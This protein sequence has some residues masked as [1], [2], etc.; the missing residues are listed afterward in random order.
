MTGQYTTLDKE[1]RPALETRDPAAYIATINAWHT[2]RL[3]EPL[4]VACSYEHVEMAEWLLQH[5]LSPNQRNRLKGGETPLH[6]AVE[7]ENAALV[8]V[9]ARYGAGLLPNHQGENPLQVYERRKRTWKSKTEAQQQAEA[10]I[11]RILAGLEA[12]PPE[13]NLFDA[14]MNGDVETLRALLAAGS[15]PVDEA[16]L[17]DYTPLLWA[18]EQGQLACAE[19]LL[20]DGADVNYVA[21]PPSGHEITPLYAAI[22]ARCAPLVRLLLARGAEVNIELDFDLCT[23][24]MRILR[25]YKGCT[26]E[27]REKV[28]Q[29]PAVYAKWKPKDLGLS[30]L[31]IVTLLLEAGADVNHVAT[32][33][34]D[35]PG[36][37]PL[38]YAVDLGKTELVA[39]L[40][41]FGADSDIENA[42]GERPLDRL[43]YSDASEEDVTHI[44]KLLVSDSQP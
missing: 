20:D 18:A 10:E 30:D 4:A 23:P 16:D 14:A 12:L 39:L 40:L 36:F 44:Q 17:E 13:P 25:D 2:A 21:H 29:H 41:R 42:D 38:H 34:Q 33:D 28:A 24:L 9:L 1:L 11:R 6:I 19:A 3:L 7:K 32:E 26:P 8:E 27:F 37:T 5:G 15:F 35:Q 43:E 31:D 22:D